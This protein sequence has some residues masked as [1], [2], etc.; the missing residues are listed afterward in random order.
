MKYLPA[1]TQL[2]QDTLNEIRN[3]RTRAKTIHTYRAQ[4]NKIMRTLR[5]INPDGARVLG[6]SGGT[7]AFILFKLDI[8]GLESLK[9]KRLIKSLERIER[10]TGGTF[11]YTYDP[12]YNALPTREFRL[13]VKPHF[14]LELE[15]CVTAMVKADAPGCRRVKVGENV[16]IDAVYEIQCD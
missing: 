6:Y 7:K 9:E 14:T 16:R 8:T 10:A 15:V 12:Q 3:T 5:S 1:S 4:I 13:T 11:G 2:R